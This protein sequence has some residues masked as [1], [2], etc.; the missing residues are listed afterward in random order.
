MQRSAKAMCLRR[1]EKPPS[2]ASR[3]R[4]LE[5]VLELVAQWFRT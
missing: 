5:G 1:E 4:G 2:L 3:N